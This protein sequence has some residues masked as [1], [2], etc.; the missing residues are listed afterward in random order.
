MLSDKKITP[1][2]LAVLAYV[3]PMLISI[4]PMLAYFG[5]AVPMGIFLK[6]KSDDSLSV[7]SRQSFV[8]YVL[9]FAVNILFLM[10]IPSML[11]SSSVCLSGPLSVFFSLDLYANTCAWVSLAFTIA[12]EVISAICLF[13][14]LS[15]KQ[16]C[17]P[18]ITKFALKI[19]KKA[20]F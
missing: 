12:A 14:V 20:D 2:S 19:R 18:L 3:L 7:H 8:I 6:C 9:L 13:A 10:L 16:I 15:G 17:M 4:T 5:W 1:E 11:T